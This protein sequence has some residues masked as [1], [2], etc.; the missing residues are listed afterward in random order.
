MG[1]SELSVFRT[2]GLGIEAIWLLGQL[3]AVGTRVERIHGAAQITVR[4]AGASGLVAARDE[5]P[6]RHAAVRGW[7][8][9]KEERLQVANELAEGA[10]LLRL[11]AGA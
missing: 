2:I 1:E 6:P 11:T 8:S 3:H 5:P 9:G 4:G 10:R 7:P